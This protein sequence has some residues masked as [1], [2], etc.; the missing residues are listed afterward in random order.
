LGNHSCA[1]CGH[2]LIEGP[3]GGA[4]QN[5]YCSNRDDCRVGFN[6]TFW[7]G[8]LLLAQR[9]GKVADET[10]AMYAPD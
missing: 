10:F 2:V 4:A 7:A 9:I 1:D 6:L 8:A 5:W 3:C